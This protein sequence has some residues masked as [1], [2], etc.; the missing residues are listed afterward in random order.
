MLTQTHK[1]PVLLI[2]LFCI[3]CGIRDYDFFR[4]VALVQFKNS[5]RSMWYKKNDK[6]F[7]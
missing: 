3:H 7:P 4:A 1:Q 6:V 5:L 2:Q